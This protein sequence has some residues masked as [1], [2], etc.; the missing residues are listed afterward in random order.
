MLIE[1]RTAHKTAAL[2]VELANNRDV[3]APRQAG[4]ST[5]E[6]RGKRASLNVSVGQVIDGC[7]AGQVDHAEGTCPARD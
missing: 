5:Y 3:A 1:D 6:G 7:K 4:R 2:R